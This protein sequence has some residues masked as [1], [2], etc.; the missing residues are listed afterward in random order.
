MFRKFTKLNWKSSLKSEGV[1]NTHIL[2]SKQKSPEA[3]TKI[4]SFIFR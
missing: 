4:N 3:N 1:L 2:I